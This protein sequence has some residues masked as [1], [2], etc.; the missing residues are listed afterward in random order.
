MN[1]LHRPA[2][3]TTSTTSW[4]KEGAMS[5]QSITNLL[6]RLSTIVETG[7]RLD[8]EINHDDPGRT[9]AILKDRLGEIVADIECGKYGVVLQASIDDV[10]DGI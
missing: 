2:T 5:N 8:N 6:D 4:H 1:L 9:L 10:L 7:K 3:S